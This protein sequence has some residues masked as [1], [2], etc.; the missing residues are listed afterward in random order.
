MAGKMCY[1]LNSVPNDPALSKS[2]CEGRKS[3]IDN[4][5]GAV[6]NPHP[7]GSPANE[8]WSRGFLSYN[9]P[10]GDLLPV[11][12]CAERGTYAA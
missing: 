5:P 1:G 2:Y 6:Q 3:S 12:C 4:W 8:A 9:G 7:D 10:S 11:D